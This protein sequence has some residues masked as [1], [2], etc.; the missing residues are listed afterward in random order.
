MGPSL[1]NATIEQL[2]KRL[3]ELTEIEDQE[4]IDAHYTALKADFEGNFFK[5]ENSYGNDTKWLVYTKVI[6]VRKEHLYV[7][8]GTVY[9]HFEGFSFEK[10]TNGNINIQNINGSFIHSLGEEIS[11]DEFNAAWD[12]TMSEINKLKTK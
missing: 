1:K 5:S 2:R 8:N 9:S 11:V 12:N 3:K 4:L 6:S 7:S 10:D